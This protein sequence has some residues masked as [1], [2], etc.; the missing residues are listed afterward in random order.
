MNI[1]KEILNKKIGKIVSGSIVFFHPVND[2]S[3]ESSKFNEFCG[4]FPEGFR[5]LNSNWLFQE[6]AS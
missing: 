3:L 2:I 1:I 5:R 4:R 6:V